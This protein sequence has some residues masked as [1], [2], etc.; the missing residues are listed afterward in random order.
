MF[1]FADE[2]DFGGIRGADPANADPSRRI[3][4]RAGLPT[5]RPGHGRFARD[6][7]AA[8]GMCRE[9]EKPAGT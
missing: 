1:S 9:P 4:E 7:A 6:A 2:T 5:Q 3:R 8:T